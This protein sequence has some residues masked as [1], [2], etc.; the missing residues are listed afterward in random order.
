MCKE[1]MHITI[2]YYVS[3]WSQSTINMTTSNT[4]Y[5][6]FTIYVMVFTKSWFY[7]QYYPTQYFHVAFWVIH[8]C[9]NI[10]VFYLRL[11]LYNAS[12]SHTIFIHIHTIL[13]SL[14]K[15]KDALIHINI[16]LFLLIQH[17]MQYVESLHKIVSWIL[18]AGRQGGMGEGIWFKF[19]REAMTCHD[20]EH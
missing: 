5:H 6:I 14:T 16:I 4:K 15:T 12:K 3:S 17:N 20:A 8:I 13:R 2:T 1:T 18:M 9:C 19:T 11:V 10:A 7:G